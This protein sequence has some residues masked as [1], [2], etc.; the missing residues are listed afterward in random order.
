MISHIGF[1]YHD[2][3]G[4]DIEYLAQA[5]DAPVKR[6]MRR[7]QVNEQDLV[8]GM[9]NDCSQFGSEIGQFARIKLAEE[10]G[11]L[12]VVAAAGAG[13]RGMAKRRS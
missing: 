1:L 4:S 13:G 5:F 7:T 8:L 9:V 12:S 10:N 2:D 11:K 6:I 3:P